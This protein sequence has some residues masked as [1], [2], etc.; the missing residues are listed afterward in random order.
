MKIAV[1]HQRMAT[2]L[3]E[4]LGGHWWFEQGS[5]HPILHFMLKGKEW[6]FPVPGTSSDPARTNKHTRSKLQ[7]KIRC[8]QEGR[9]YGGCA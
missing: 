1:E 7:R 4:P 2:D 8:I 6:K 5:K 9:Q 3:I